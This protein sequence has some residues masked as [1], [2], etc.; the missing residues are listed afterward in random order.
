VTRK[1]IELCCT[2]FVRHFIFQSRVDY[3]QVWITGTFLQDVSSCI[4][5][6][7][8]FQK[9]ANVCYVALVF[10]VQLTTRQKL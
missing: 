5:K 7:L 4:G 3:Y 10:G 8:L 2:F 1:L 9:I 6:T